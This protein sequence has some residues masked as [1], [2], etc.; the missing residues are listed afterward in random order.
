MWQLFYNPEHRSLYVLKEQ[1]STDPSRQI[2]LRS[3]ANATLVQNL[4]NKAIKYLAIVEQAKRLVWAVEQGAAPAI[5]T[6]R[7]RLADLLAKL[8]AARID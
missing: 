4:L 7:R 5:E 2:R 1:G 8:E 6:E 3:R